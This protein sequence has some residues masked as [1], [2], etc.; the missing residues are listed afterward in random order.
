MAHFFNH[1][2]QPLIFIICVIPIWREKVK[3]E[4]TIL[5]IEK[6]NCANSWPSA[7][8]IGSS[9]IPGRKKSASSH[10]NSLDV[11]HWLLVLNTREWRKISHTALKFEKKYKLWKMFTHLFS[12]LFEI[13]LFGVYIG[14]KCFDFLSYWC[15]HYY[16]LKHPNM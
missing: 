12:I 8:N 15:D 1:T 10:N 9:H 5:E 6:K 7:E 3:V 2:N 4:Y 14:K 11:N 16:Y 13:F